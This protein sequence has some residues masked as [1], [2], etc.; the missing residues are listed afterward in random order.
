[1]G[2]KGSGYIET[3]KRQALFAPGVAMP[4]ECADNAALLLGEGLR[5]VDRLTDGRKKY[6]RLRQILLDSQAA[7][8]ATNRRFK[9]VSPS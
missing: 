4:R 1:M 7:S 9:V 3:P 6:S 5:T 2:R 8:M